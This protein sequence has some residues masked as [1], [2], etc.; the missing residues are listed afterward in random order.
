MAQIM[1]ALGAF[2]F[3]IDTAAYQQ[4]ERVWSY[5]WEPQD[6]IGRQV[7]MQFT[8]TGATEINIE[9]IIYPAYRG[10]LD[11]VERMAAIAGTGEPQRLVDGRGRIWGLFVITEV[12]ETQKVFGPSGAARRVDFAMQLKSY[13]S[14]RG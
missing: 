14:D 9:G 8:G 3:S 13:G 6:R 7:A 2:R 5:R 10:G 1:M 4:L 12:R 11:Q